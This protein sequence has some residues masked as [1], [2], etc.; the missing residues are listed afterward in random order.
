MLFKFGMEFKFI[1]GVF[2]R[3]CVLLG[4]PYM[5]VECGSEYIADAVTQLI[6]SVDIPFIV[7]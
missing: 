2:R 4:C 3:V 6:P 5:Q 7:S 1:M